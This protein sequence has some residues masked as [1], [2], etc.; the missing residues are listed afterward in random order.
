MSAPNGRFVFG[1]ISGSGK[2]QFML[3][4]ATG[5]LWRM[6]ESGKVGIFLKAVPYL[7][8]EGEGTFLPDRVPDPEPKKSEKK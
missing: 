2:D 5:R 3:D 4:T 1:Q 8:A 6:G 7:D